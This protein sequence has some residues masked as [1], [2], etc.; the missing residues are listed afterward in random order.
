MKPFSV[1]LVL[2]ICNLAELIL[3]LIPTVR[4]YILIAISI[5]VLLN[6]HLIEHLLHISRAYRLKEKTISS[7]FSKIVNHTKSENREEWTMKFFS[8]IQEHCSK[9]KRSTF[10]L[11]AQEQN[12]KLSSIPSINIYQPFSRTQKQL[13][14]ISSNT[15]TV[16][17]KIYINI[18]NVQVYVVLILVLYSFSIGRIFWGQNVVFGAKMCNAWVKKWHSEAKK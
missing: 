2:G 17:W 1:I 9:Y 4:L 18:I 11:V 7:F 6:V 8:T 3:F 15:N 12:P 16:L 5:K 10:F 14:S 13:F